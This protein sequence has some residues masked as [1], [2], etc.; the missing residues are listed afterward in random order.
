VPDHTQP[1]TPASG[2]IQ[3]LPLDEPTNGEMVDAT[4][5]WEPWAKTAAIPVEAGKI[6]VPPNV[7]AV[8]LPEPNGTRDRLIRSAERMP[9]DV[10]DAFLGGAG[11]IDADPGPRDDP[12]GLDG[13]FE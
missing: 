1:A 8:T 11:L 2:S 13:L 10:R 12:Y 6:V 9:K 3:V 7:G 4:F 5:P